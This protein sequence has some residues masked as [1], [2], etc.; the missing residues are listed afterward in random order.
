MT[1]CRT[2]PSRRLSELSVRSRNFFSKR[3]SAAGSPTESLWISVNGGQKRMMIILWSR[4]IACV[5]GF[6][7]LKRRGRYSVS[8]NRRRL[9]CVKN[10]PTFPSADEN[11]RHSYQ[12][13]IFLRYSLLCIVLPLNWSQWRSSGFVVCFHTF[14]TLLPV[15]LVRRWIVQL[16]ARLARHL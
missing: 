14:D 10:P 12:N 7:Q 2:A 13:V 15:L 8:C 11:W 5:A 16:R 6:G 1:S 9:T 3:S 4:N